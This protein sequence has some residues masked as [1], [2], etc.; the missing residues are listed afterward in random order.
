MPTKN[1]KLLM[2][3]VLDDD[4]M[5]IPTRLE[6]WM[7]NHAQESNNATDRVLSM[8]ADRNNIIRINTIEWMLMI[9]NWKTSTEKIVTNTDI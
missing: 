4:V 2:L 3:N 7:K 8:L 5:E 1:M 9:I 6:A